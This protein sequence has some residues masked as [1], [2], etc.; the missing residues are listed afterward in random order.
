MSQSRR[1]VRRAFLK[2]VA[3]A[4][5]AVPVF[6]RNLISAP[7]SN[8]IR[9]ASFGGGGMAAGDMTNLVNLARDEKPMLKLVCVAEVDLSR[10]DRVKKAVPDGNV[11][12]YQDW[13]ELLDKEAK[14]LDSVNVGT[15][16]H[17][18][19][20]IGM[21]AM[22]LGLHAYIQKPLAH[23]LYEVRRLT[24][25]AVEKKLVTQMGIQI[26]SSPYYRI[27]VKVIQSGAIGKVK[28]VHLWSSKKW[29]DSAP[30]PQRSDPV[31]ETLNWDLWLGVAASRP[32]I[33]DHYYHP[34][35]WRKRLDFGTG[36]FGD[37]GC[38]IYDPVYEA[39]ALTAPISVRSEG[40]APNQW[41]WATDAVIQ[42]VFPGT[43]FTEGTTIAMTWYDGGQRPSK[44]IQSLVGTKKLP[45]QGSLF[46]GTN[47]VMLLPHIGRP[48]LFPETQ[49]QDY[50][51]PH[52]SGSSHWK[53]FA[54]AI[55]GE[56]QTTAPLSY[57][58]PLTEVVLLGG[59][60]TRFP[61]ATLQWDTTA[62]K[63]TNLPEAN[64]LV[65]RTYRKGW[66][67]PGLS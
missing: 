1:T 53:Q 41:N 18:H 44:D 16:D 3:A 45:G 60:A 57:S 32:F 47:G 10:T 66:E 52:E 4:G 62:L 36:T 61:K 22:Q 28:E 54:E 26:H 58:G 59:V 51:L 14:N 11:K 24:E 29:G 39:L 35:N 50:P 49:F 15:P 63:F 40:P 31:P 21:A 19:A 46:V 23:D 12:I 43:R 38:H 6:V 30:P 48:E 20:P 5:L 34:S 65:R 13:R 9:H 55:L 17:M 8:I 33:G 67:V 37:M 64:Q 2:Q 25:V 27:G 42:Y 7:P 56:G